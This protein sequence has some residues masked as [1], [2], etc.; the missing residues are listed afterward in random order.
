MFVLLVRICDP[1]HAACGAPSEAGLESFRVFVPNDSSAYVGIGD[2]Y[3]AGIINAGLE[4]PT[5]RL[6]VT[7]GT[8]RI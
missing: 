6:H 8:I 5:E 7:D 2:F 1:D 4:D 3:R